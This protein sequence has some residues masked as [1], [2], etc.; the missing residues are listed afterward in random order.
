MVVCVERQRY[1]YS[2]I[3]IKCGAALVSRTAPAGI[4]VGGFTTVSSCGRIAKSQ[5][6]RILG[7]SG[8]NGAVSFAAYFSG[9]ICCAREI[10]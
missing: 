7:S 2:Q 6:T 10:S 9:K 5:L 3:S 4:P 8:V 1:D